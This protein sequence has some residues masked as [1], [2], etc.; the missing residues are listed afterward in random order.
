VGKKVRLCMSIGDSA[1]G[2]FLI[3]EPKYTLASEI[4]LGDLCI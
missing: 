4:Y 1:A 3:W 2:F